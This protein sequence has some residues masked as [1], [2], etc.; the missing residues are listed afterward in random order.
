VSITD[1]NGSSR[2]VLTNPFGY[3]RFD[4]V[5]SGQAYVVGVRSK[6]YQFANPTQIV[7]VEDNVT[8]IIFYAS[9]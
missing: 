1:Q 6:R 7:S 5:E 9:P 8:G 3:F 4:D 2:T